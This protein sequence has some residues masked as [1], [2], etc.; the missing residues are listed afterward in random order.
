MLGA[1]YSVADLRKAGYPGGELRGA[2]VTATQ[3]KDAGAGAGDAKMA[4]YSAVE[5]CT[6]EGWTVEMLRAGGAGYEATLHA[7]HNLIPAH[8][9]CSAASS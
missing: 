1:S 4:G 9:P 2:G 7:A 6:V 8:N 5:A 3:L